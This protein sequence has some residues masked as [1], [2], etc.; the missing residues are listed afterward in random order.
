MREPGRRKYKCARARARTRAGAGAGAGAG[1]R[2]RAGACIAPV[3][4]YLRCM[5]EPALI[6]L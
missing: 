3:Y 6:C 5:C 1:A 2:T 4:A